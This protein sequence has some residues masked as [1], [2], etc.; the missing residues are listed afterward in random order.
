MRNAYTGEIKEEQRMKIK[1]SAPM[2]V[3]AHD[4]IVRDFISANKKEQPVTWQHIFSD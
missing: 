1:D 3:T 2:L 4:S